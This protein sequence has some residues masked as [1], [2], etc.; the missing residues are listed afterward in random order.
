MSTI[1]KLLGIVPTPEADG[2]FSPSPVALKLATE[3]K[4]DY[5]PVA[6]PE[7]PEAKTQRVMVICTEQAHMA[8]RNG[9]KFLTGNHPVEMFVPLLHLERAGFK[10]DVFTPTGRPAQIEK[11]ALPADDDAVQGI[12]ARYQPH[13]ERP[14][15]LHDFVQQGLTSDT[16][17]VA[18]FFPGGHG[19]ML[20]LPENE[21]VGK[22]IHW[23]HEHDRYVLAIC[24]APAALLAANR[25]AS[26]EAFVYRGYQMAVFPDTLDKI[27][28]LFG[29]MPGP[30]SWHFG[31]K[32]KALGV[33]IINK[34]ASGTC[35]RDRHLIT[36]D[37]PQA[38]NAFG[39]M[40]VEALLGE[41]SAAKPP[42]NRP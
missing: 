2:S 40:A 36:G 11:W 13:L 34:T 1:K 16:P 17:Y 28:P 21:D 42:R 38:A 15:S 14:R 8:M 5:A 31:E 12:Y 35:H 9:K 41:V 24:H 39:I 18:V 20:G 10:I 27:T 33:E 29:Y 22:I 26:P 37:G 4:T 6:Y 23:A 19:A 7:T 32:L 30:M 3:R 25:E